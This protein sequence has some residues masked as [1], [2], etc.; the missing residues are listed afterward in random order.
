[1]TSQAPIIMITNARTMVSQYPIPRCWRSRS[2][3]LSL[4]STATVFSA[5][6]IGVAGLGTAAHLST[7]IVPSAEEAEE[8][9]PGACSFERC[10]SAGGGGRGRGAGA[11]RAR[12]GGAAA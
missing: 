2:M 5:D 12:A 4:S 9:L 8:A 1:M 3:A 11:G 7:D 10:A 6:L